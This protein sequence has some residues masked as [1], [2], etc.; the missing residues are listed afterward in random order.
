MV[1]ASRNLGTGAPGE[2]AGQLRVL[3][4]QLGY[5]AL[6]VQELL[7]STALGCRIRLNECPLCCLLCARQLRSQPGQRCRAVRVEGESLTKLL[8]PMRPRKLSG[9]AST[10]KPYGCPRKCG[11]LGLL[12]D[13]QLELSLALLGRSVLLKHPVEAFV[14]D[15]LVGKRPRVLRHCGFA[16]NG[17]AAKAGGALV[18][19]VQPPV[20]VCPHLRWSVAAAAAVPP[21]VRCGRAASTASYGRGR[22]SWRVRASPELAMALKPSC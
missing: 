21:C 3:R 12:F 2:L 5:S 8:L 19:A 20:V 17:Q 13:L 22:G 7:S 18:R 11:T 14:V 1:T 4:A 15:P 6:C 16:S 10:S 9:V